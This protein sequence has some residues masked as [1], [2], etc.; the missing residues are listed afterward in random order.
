MSLTVIVSLSLQ[1][2]FI[3]AQDRLPAAFPK[4]VSSY[5]FKVVGAAVLLLT[6]LQI[7]LISL[8]F[9]WGVWSVT[10]VLVVLAVMPPFAGLVEN[11]LRTN[12]SDVFDPKRFPGHLLT[13]VVGALASSAFVWAALST[14]H[15]DEFNKKFAD[16][17]AFNIALPL[18][19]A[20]AIAFVRSEQERRSGGLDLRTASDEVAEPAIVG[21]SLRHVHQLLNTVFLAVVV[22]SAGATMLYLFAQTISS[23][24]AGRPLDVSW[25]VI[26]SIVLT[27]LFFLGCG[28]PQSRGS[29][30]VW[31]TF[32]T[33]TPAVLIMSLIWLALLQE[34]TLRNAT[35]GVV[36]GGAYV[37]YCVE[38]ILSE[39]GNGN[40]IELHYFSSVMVLFVLAML[41]GA[42][43]LS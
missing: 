35:I 43:Y 19:T 8:L 23:A 24:K 21:Y 20:V 37:A 41:L 15:F 42:V 33:G 6:G 3:L 5:F 30:T 13:N 17:A 2:I 39:R 38:F 18:A 27:M 9:A 10:I 26:L 7:S 22:F 16:D 25:P 1:A 4:K 32:V 29:R 40:K 31:M 11:R 34:S 14:P 12:G 28:L 36:V